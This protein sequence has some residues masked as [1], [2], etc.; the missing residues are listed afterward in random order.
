MNAWQTLNSRWLDQPFEVAIETQAI[1]NA[2]CTFCP[3]DSMERKGTRMSDELLD[4][5]VREMSTWK[6][7]FWLSPF[8][9]SEPLIDKR[10]LPLIERVNAEVPHCGIRIFTNGSPL[11]D[12]VIE[13]LGSCQRVE[14]Y[15]SLNTHIP[16]EYEK[17]MGLKWERVT[18]RL[19][20][21]HASKFR[22]PVKL[23]KVG[24]DVNHVF[25][26]YCEDRWPGFRVSIT[27]QDSWLGFTTSESN[28]IP[29][30]PCGRWWELSIMAD[31][32]VAHCCMDS[33]GKFQVGEVR[34]HSMLDVY[35]HPR[36]R[37][38]R[39]MLMSRQQIHP[40]RTCSY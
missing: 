6:E 20:A 3:Y 19:D 38:R 36:I 10:V 1:C 4:K 16:E 18:A 40:C 24:K 39:Q 14:L 13:R 37:R 5:L 21:L 26:R 22:H 15:V 11:T 33:E 30:A 23:L 12:A 17:L 25:I 34:E 8:K 32:T 9:V 29:D 31:G 2:H 7:P 35:N 28:A 27:K